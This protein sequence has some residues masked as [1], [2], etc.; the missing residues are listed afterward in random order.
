MRT[1]SQNEIEKVSGGLGLLA[2]I[3]IDLKPLLNLGIGISVKTSSGCAPKHCEPRHG[4][5]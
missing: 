5:C 4:H 1:L 3:G 2:A